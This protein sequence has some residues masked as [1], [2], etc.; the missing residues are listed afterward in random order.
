MSVKIVFE[1][2]INHSGELKLAKKLI[3]VAAASGCDYVKFQKRHIPTVYTPEELSQPRISPY[4]TTNGD[5]KR[6]LEFDQGEFTEINRYCDAK[7]LG[8]I[9]WF[10]SCWDHLSVGLMEALFPE[11]PYHK[12]PSALITN[13]Q[14][15]ESIKATNRPVIISTGMS[16]YSE[17]MKCTEYLGPQIEYVLACTSTYPSKPEEQNLLNILAL[18][19]KFPQYRIGFSNHSPGLTFMIAAVSLGAEMIEFHGTLDRSM[20]GSDQAASIEPEGVFKLV[21]HIRSLEL[22]M[23]DG[24]KKIYDS[25]IPILKKLRR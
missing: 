22:G 6:Q 4:G 5:L 1:A 14:L 10:V 18:K 2:G 21:K 16:T 7:G 24:V 15:L 20:F 13:F 12:I 19:E 23:G 17:I 3:D 8:R 9:D 25:E 11:M